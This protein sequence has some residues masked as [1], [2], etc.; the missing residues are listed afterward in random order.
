MNCRF[1]D[2]RNL[3]CLADNEDEEVWEYATCEHFE[4]EGGSHE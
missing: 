1:Y 3:T 2:R 4:Q